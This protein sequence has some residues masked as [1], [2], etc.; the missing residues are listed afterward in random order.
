MAMR[1]P[2]QA[3]QTFFS[4]PLLLFHVLQ[5]TQHLPGSLLDS[6]QFTSVFLILPK[7]ASHV[8]SQTPKRRK[9]IS[10]P[11]SAGSTGCIL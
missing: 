7:R 1:S 2:L 10:S 9:R 11:H 4:Q 3:E 8:V 6:H 5:P